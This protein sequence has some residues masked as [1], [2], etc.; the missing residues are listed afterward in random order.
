MVLGALCLLS[1]AFAQVSQMEKGTGV[2]SVDVP[3][4]LELT[5][6][7]NP[8]Y[9]TSSQ[10]VLIHPIVSGGAFV[11]R[12]VMVGAGFGI[13]QSWARVKTPSEVT[14]SK[15]SL[16]LTPSVMVRYYH[17]F[18]PKFGIYGQLSAEAWLLGDKNNTG[19]P[20][21]FRVNV[22]LSP[23][24]VFLPKPFVGINVG[25]GELGYGL[26]SQENQSLMGTVRTI[27]H[28]FLMYPTVHVG[29]SFFIGRAS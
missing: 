18:T 6:S 12:N 21:E 23:R 9:K 19:N 16:Y 3:F 28:N 24:M 20:D 26:T 1:E 13:V 15:S 14:K 10:A 22:M 2:V 7:K 4:F 11:A 29:T 5:S 17:M 25:L 8:N 27:S